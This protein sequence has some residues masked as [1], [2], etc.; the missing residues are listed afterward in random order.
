[1]RR[2]CCGMLIVMLAA[3]GAAATEEAPS[4]AP[5]S[6]TFAP[7]LNIDL[8]AMQRMDGG[9]LVRDVREGG[10]RTVGRGDDVAVRYAGWLPDGTMVDANVAPAAP[11]E[12]R[13]G[14]RQVIRGWDQGVVGMRV[15]G[16]RQLIVPPS[17][18]YGNRQVG[19]I[20]PN[21]TL[22]FLVEVVSAR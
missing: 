17:L 18:G 15:G 12:F 5:E 20:P 14:E 7:A 1:M 21:A 3:C 13:L 8:A 2:L 19:S 9:L 16:Q 22:V 11:R 4:V 6:L 10:G